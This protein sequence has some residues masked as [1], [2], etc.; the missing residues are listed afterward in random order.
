MKNIKK[1][2]ALLFLIL[3]SITGFSQKYKVTTDPIS[4]E[5]IITATYQD[6]WVYMENHGEET[7]LSVVKGYLGELNIEAPVGSEF[8][9]KLDN[10]EIIKLATT[11][12]AAPNSYLSQGVVYTNYTFETS[13]SKEVLT[14]LSEHAPI[15][16]RLP[17]MKSGDRDMVEKKYFKVINAGAKY[18]LAN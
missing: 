5:K 1:I 15:L 12:A 4:G 14:K 6:K 2:V 10:N 8:I 7:K 13:L 18:I 3:C 17:D 16:I 9:V 11:V